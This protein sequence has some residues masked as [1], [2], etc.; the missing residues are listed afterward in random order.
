MTTET[1]PSQKGLRPILDG[2][3]SWRVARYAERTGRPFSSAV[4][5]MI[6]KAWDAYNEQMHVEVSPGRSVPGEDFSTPRE[7]VS[8]YLSKELMAEIRRIADVELR[9]NSNVATQ[10]M[11]EG[12]RVRRAAAEK[13][14]G[15]NAAVLA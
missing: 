5:D 12:L 10:L 2:I 1:Q 3:S 4:R 9:T 15:V 6:S 11:I 14:A 8:F 13:G 7:P